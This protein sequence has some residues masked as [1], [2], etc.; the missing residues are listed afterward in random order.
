M[1]L[2]P[3][4]QKCLLTEG[5][6]HFNGNF[7]P[8]AACDMRVVN[9]M[10]EIGTLSDNGAVVTHGDSGESYTL[11]IDTTGIK[12]HGAGPAGAFYG[13]QTLRQLI[14]EYGNDLP[15]LV[16]E[17]AP[18]FAHRG[19]Y[20]DVTRG[21]VPTLEMLYRIVDTLAA[22]K[23]NELQLYVEDAFAFS[24]YD[25]I[26]PDTCKL[27][28][29]EILALDEYCYAHFI[30]LI[31][32]ASTF[33]HLYNLLQSEKYKHL[34]E[35]ED[36]QPTKHYWLEKMSHHTIDVNNPESIEVIGSMIDEYAP[37]FRSNT[38]NICCDE[39]FDLCKGKN[40][41]K[42]VAKAYCDFLLKIIDRVKKHGKTVQMWGDIVLK[43]PEVLPLL[44]KDT[45]MLNW[46]YD[47][48]PGLSGC[49]VFAASGLPQIV[50]PG[51]S[52]WSRF[53]ENVSVGLSN[54]S[55]MAKVGHTYGAMGV[56]NTNWG[57]F[58]N[59]CSFYTTCFGMAAGAECSWSPNAPLD[60]A[61]K[62]AVAC[63]LYG[64]CHDM[65]SIAERLTVAENT[66]SLS[67]LVYWYSNF[68]K[69]DIRKSSM[70][71]VNEEACTAALAAC[72]AILSELDDMNAPDTPVFHDLKIAVDAVAV[73]NRI[74]L[75]LKGIEGYETVEGLDDFIKELTEAWLRDNK[76][77]QLSMLTEFF[78]TLSTCKTEPELI[79]E[80][81]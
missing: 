79:A 34:C 17:D 19:F 73:M 29:E 11:C 61:F 37:L 1:H 38:F 32:S 57:D 67:K 21:K 64:V 43:H 44:P 69:N 27:S 15:C 62:D 46:N 60:H 18:G 75:R 71:S 72:D 58:G 16:V 53:A 24:V 49:D 56:L 78:L 80:R 66:C 5:T 52:T 6:F 35:F 28:K 13:L 63:Q 41:G 42:D 68:F 14:K 33:G 20:H 36:Y 81:A 70:A 3:R 77:S 74:G 55:A 50:C 47:A 65:Y 40:A 22:M 7:S 45:I 8:M 26:I 9:A 25:G 76:V 48:D 39:T 10:G 31:P 2:I 4:P 12:L 59:P 30:E 54:I 51:T 23:V